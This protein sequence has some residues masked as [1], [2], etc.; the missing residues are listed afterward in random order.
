MRARLAVVF[1]LAWA[2]VRTLISRLFGARTGLALFRANYAED[3]LPAATAEERA[4]PSLSG[5]IACGL[6]DLGLDRP[7]GG[8]MDLALASSRATIDADAAEV[9]LAKLDDDALLAREAL[10]P[11]R[12]PLLAVARLTRARAAAVS[13]A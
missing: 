9:G 13:G 12:V 8:A 7:L 10:C 11:T 5:C 1:V 2:L 3:R 6:C 4:L